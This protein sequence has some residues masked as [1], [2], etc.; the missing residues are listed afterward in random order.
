MHGQAVHPVVGELPI[1]AELNR[2]RI[3]IFDL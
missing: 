3:I 1:H 2:E